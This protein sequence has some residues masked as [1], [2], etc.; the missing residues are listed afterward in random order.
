MSLWHFAREVGM[1]IQA[2]LNLI[3]AVPSSTFKTLAARPINT[4]YDITKMRTM[5]IS[6]VEVEAGLAEMLAME[7]RC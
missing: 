2:D 1:A 4:T 5:L 6:P 3:E 7:G